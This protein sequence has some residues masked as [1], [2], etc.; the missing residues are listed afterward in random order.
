MKNIKINVLEKGYRPLNKLDTSTPPVGGS[1]V[2]SCPPSTNSA[3]QNQPKSHDAKRS[4]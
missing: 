1:A 3:Q 4:K 2:L